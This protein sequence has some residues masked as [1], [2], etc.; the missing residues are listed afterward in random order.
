MAETKV[1]LTGEYYR[2]KYP[3]NF[4]DSLISFDCGIGWKPLIDK[5]FEVMKN[6]DIKVEQVKEK[7]GGLR[8]YTDLSNDEV[9]EIISEAE[10]ESFKT[11]E[12][13]GAKDDV[14]TEGGWLKTLCKDCRK[15]KN[16]H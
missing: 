5:I 4:S 7:F 15:N 8:F 11:C 1:W 14:T 10:A 2:N 9:D 16:S 3:H 12:F 13:C 6:T